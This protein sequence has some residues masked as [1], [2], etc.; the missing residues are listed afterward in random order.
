[1]RNDACF[2][3]CHNSLVGCLVSISIKYCY[4]DIANRKTY[5]M[6]YN[7]QCTLPK[8]FCN[9]K[10]LWLLEICTSGNFRQGKGNRCE[11]FSFQSPSWTFYCEWGRYNS[12]TP[13]RKCV[14]FASP[15]AIWGFLL[16]G[17]RT[18]SL[19]AASINQYLMLYIFNSFML[20]SFENI[21][22]R[23]G[24]FSSVGPSVSLNM[25]AYNYP[26]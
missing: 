23:S 5:R 21:W 12:P 1:M 20:I 26:N 3:E 8:T 19:V 17:Y 14:L 15:S 7:M 10:P 11:L 9:A 4:W 25:A 16:C 2:F 22:E 24:V 18:G 13:A 6:I